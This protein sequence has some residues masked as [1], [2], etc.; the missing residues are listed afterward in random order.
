MA[1]SPQTAW[2]GSLLNH[3]ECRR[4]TTSGS[5]SRVDEVGLS[6]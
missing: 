1:T 2:L 5:S 6:R 3:S 4:L